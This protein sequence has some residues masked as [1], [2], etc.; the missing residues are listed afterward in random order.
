MIHKAAYTLYI[1]IV[2][3]LKLNL[4]LKILTFSAEFEKRA[5]KDV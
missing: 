3:I 2:E 4:R 1:Y 5:S